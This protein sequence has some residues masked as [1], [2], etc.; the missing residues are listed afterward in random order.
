M[1]PRVRWAAVWALAAMPLLGWWLYGLFDLDEGFYGAIVAE[2]NRRGEWVTPLFNGKPWFE[3]PILLYWLTKP[4][5]AL[6]GE[7]AGPRLPS[8]LCALGT[9][10][11]IAWFAR[12]H[13]GR[14]AA[15]VSVLI[16]ASSLL[17]VG[18][19][20]MMLT[21]PPLVFCLTAA[22]LTFWESLVGDRRWRLVSAAAIGF[23]I[24]AKGPVAAILFV[25]VALW[26][27]W[28]EPQLR[29][30]FRGGWLVGTA[31][32]TL[33]VASWYVPAYQANGQLFVQKF[34]IEQ[35]VG[36]FTGGD[37]AHTLGIASLPLYVPILFVGM[38]PWSVWLWNAWPRRPKVAAPDSEVAKLDFGDA[39]RRYLATAGA[40][41]FLFFSVSGAKLPHYILPCLPPFALLIGAYLAERRWSLRLGAAM[42]VVMCLVA[43][44]V[45]LWWYEAS[46]QREAH[47]LTRYLRRLPGDVALYQLS[48]RQKELGTGKPKLQETSLPSVIMYLNRDVIDTDSLP[49]LLTH[50]GELW[51]FTRAGRFQPEDFVT[52]IKAGRRLEQI[53]PTLKLENYALY[54]IR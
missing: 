54:R 14:R 39:L 40:V 20:R 45:F 44:G 46:G 23:G 27:L 16:L 52:A 33:I 29:P 25:I 38:I 4:S 42:C 43:N 51:V 34:L 7:M 22:F 47:A 13:L 32:L 49:A 2:M 41:V 10:G 6:F 35:N 31:I 1:S 8:V 37:A 17:M 19:S 50:P 21:D 12:R 28:R 9:Y 18:A 5:M 53:Q 11:V 24:L 3:K 15:Q 48:R 36:R 30:N 26:T